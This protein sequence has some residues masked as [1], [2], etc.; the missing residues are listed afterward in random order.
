[1]MGLPLAFAEP[2]VLLGLISLP[3][4]WWLL[5]LIPPRPQRIHFPPT[6]LLFDIVPKEETPSRTPWWLL[7]LRLLLAALLIIAAA[8][9]LWNPPIAAS[10]AASPLALLIDDGWS[11]AATWD[12]RVRTAEDLISRAESNKTGVAI[13]LLSDTA[14]DISLETP[15]A[16][17][18]RL[19]QIRPKPHTPARA[20]ALPMITKFLTATPDAEVVWLSDGVDLGHASEFVE[21][22]ARAASG[23]PITVVEGGIDP[24]RA[25]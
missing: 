9:P 18:V 5:R 21:G 23:R 22:L 10:S 24:A 8:G 25:R 4:L 7:L 14:R 3:A 20:D 12:R 2:L 17:R 11:A 1:M 13:I 16:A 19:N 6:R 15:G